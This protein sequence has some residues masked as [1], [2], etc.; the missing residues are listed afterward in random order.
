MSGYR[1]RHRLRHMAN[2]HCW[3]RRPSE[4]LDR[5]QD[6]DGFPEG[7]MPMMGIPIAQVAQRNDARDPRDR[8][9]EEDMHM[10]LVSS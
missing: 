8:E 6:S 4:A 7:D 2:P 1:H 5:S 9:E 3:F 10:A